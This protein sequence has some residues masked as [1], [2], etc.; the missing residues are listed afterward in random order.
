MLTTFNVPQPVS[1][2]V[3]SQTHSAIPWVTGVPLYD[4]E[5]TLS[6]IK[7][8]RKWGFD[9]TVAICLLAHLELLMLHSCEGPSLL[10]YQFLFKIASK[11]LSHPHNKHRKQSYGIQVQV[12]HQLKTNKDKSSA[13]QPVVRSSYSVDQP[14]AAIQ[15]GQLC[16]TF[17]KYRHNGKWDMHLHP[18]NLII[19]LC[20]ST[21]LNTSMVPAPRMPT[22]THLFVSSTFSPS[23]CITLSEHRGALH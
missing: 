21:T 19:S 4:I 13:V 12:S 9:R 16:T 6:M 14:L 10:L 22:I 7:I 23:V 20:Q 18:H 15:G 11:A 3:L 8:Y 5:L 2:S 17:S 1:T